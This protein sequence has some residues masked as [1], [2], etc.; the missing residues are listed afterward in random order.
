MLAIDPE[1]ADDQLIFPNAETLSQVKV[2][3]G[4]TSAEEQSFDS[5][6]QAVLLGA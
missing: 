3:R 6:F 2:F 5:A 4:L 1:L